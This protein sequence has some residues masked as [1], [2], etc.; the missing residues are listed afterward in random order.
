M[1]SMRKLNISNIFREL[2]VQ[3]VE[4]KKQIFAYSSFII[5]CKMI[6]GK[7]GEST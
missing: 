5:D 1:S 6:V 7:A 4:K 3:K 2:V